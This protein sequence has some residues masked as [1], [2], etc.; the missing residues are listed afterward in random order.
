MTTATRALLALLAAAVLAVGC[1]TDTDTPATPGTDALDAVTDATPEA[2][3]TTLPPV[4]APTTT[5]V[6]VDVDAVVASVKESLGA[7][8]F[9]AE[10]DTVDQAIANALVRLGYALGAVTSDDLG[11]IIA[12]LNRDAADEALAAEAEADASLTAEQRNAVGSAE[13]YMSWG[14]FSR[15]GL[16]DQLEYE[17]FTTADA[18][19][20]VDSLGADWMAQAVKSAEGYLEWGHFSRQELIDQLVYEGFTQAEAEHG[21]AIAYR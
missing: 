5:T 11:N 10:T 4:T 17:G 8:W 14:D 6:A 16:I 1:S 20:A 15:T 18:T 19:F 2:T 9:T 7:E 13:S 3:T 12:I 21:V